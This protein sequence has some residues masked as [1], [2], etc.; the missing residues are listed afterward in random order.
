MPSLHRQIAFLRYVT[1]I[2][3]RVKNQ[4]LKPN[5]LIC[6]IQSRLVPVSFQDL[7]STFKK[8]QSSTQTKNWKQDVSFYINFVSFTYITSVADGIEP[9]TM[10]LGVQRLAA[11]LFAC[12]Q[13]SHLQLI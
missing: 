13:K 4:Q 7:K 10:Q 6:I 11:E 8:K 2:N 9:I 3:E 12:A 5:A 1:D